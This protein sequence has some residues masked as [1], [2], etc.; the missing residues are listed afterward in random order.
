E[1]MARRR[2]A[3]PGPSSTTLHRGQV[4]TR[5]WLER[6]TAA[7][8]VEAAVEAAVA[9][10]V[11]AQAAAAEQA[12]AQ[13]HDVQHDDAYGDGAI[14]HGSYDADDDV[15]HSADWTHLP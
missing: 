5:T 9:E 7:A 6:L 8:A 13:Q 11:P 3:T 15:P 14:L 12:Q 2:V 10:A 1:W 4:P